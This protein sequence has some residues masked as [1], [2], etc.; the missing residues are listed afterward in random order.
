MSISIYFVVTTDADGKVQAATTLPSRHFFPH[1]P[2]EQLAQAVAVGIAKRVP[3]AYNNAA[4]PAL[5]LAQELI[6]PEGFGHA[7]TPEV[8][9]A[10]K[11]V[12]DSTRPSPMGA[13]A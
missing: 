12:L 4:L 10:A 11:R 13:P 6:S 7:V 3:L 9:L 2:A 8:R 5:A 1:S